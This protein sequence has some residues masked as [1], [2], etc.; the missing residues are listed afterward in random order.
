MY[1][2]V[3]QPFSPSLPP[4]LPPSLSLSFSLS[5]FVLAIHC[6]QKNLENPYS[7]I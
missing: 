7:G 4:S 1:D 6:S 2:W 3:L 5:L